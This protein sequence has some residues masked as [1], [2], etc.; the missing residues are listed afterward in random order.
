MRALCIQASHGLRLGGFQ[1]HENL[2]KSQFDNER[3]TVGGG[4]SPKITQEFGSGTRT[5]SGSRDSV[6]RSPVA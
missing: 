2:R 1:G 4:V 6:P 5:I 3:P